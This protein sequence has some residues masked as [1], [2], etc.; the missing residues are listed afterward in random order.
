MAKKNV[1][2]LLVDTL[3]AGADAH[4]TGRLAVCAGSCDDPRQRGLCGRARG[5]DRP[6]G[7]AEGADRARD[8]GQGVHRV[9]QPVRRRHDGPA[10]V[11]VRLSGDDEL[12]SL[13]D[14]RHGLPVPPVLSGEGDHRADR[15]PRRAARPAREGRP[16]VRGR[17]ADD[18][19]DLLPHLDEQRD[20]KHLVAAIEHYRTART[21]LDELAT[22]GAATERSHPQYVARVLDE[23]AA[24]DAVFA[25]DVGTPTVWAA[26]Y[27]T[28]NGKRRLLG[29]F[30]HGSMANALPQAIG[31]Q[32]SHP[33]RQVVSMS[34]DGGLAMLAKVNLLLVWASGRPPC[35]CCR[36]ARRCG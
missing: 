4:L 18:P 29:S 15:H 25:C 34:G 35:G 24:D 12:R 20:D 1:A 28:M 5:A 22:A 32:I 31:A 16:R 26:R 23:L 21:S 2:D 9:R 19:S 10:R 36:R 11:L 13:A 6:R 3:V 17:Y 33:G 30:N 14:A 27:L 7:K 8:A